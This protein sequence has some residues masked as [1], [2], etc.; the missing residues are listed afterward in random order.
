M[1]IFHIIYRKI[2]FKI[3]LLFIINKIIAARFKS[4]DIFVKS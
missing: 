3:L 2:I 1:E 4:K